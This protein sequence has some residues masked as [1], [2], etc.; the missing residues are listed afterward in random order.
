MFF[1]NTFRINLPSSSPTSKRM[2]YKLIQVIGISFNRL[3]Q[4]VQLSLECLSKLYF[5]FI[6]IYLYIPEILKSIIHILK[7]DS[8]LMVLKTTQIN[9]RVVFLYGQLP[10]LI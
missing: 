6:Y 7:F 8:F 5:Q 1:A 9:F 3:A 4:S 2:N 10:K